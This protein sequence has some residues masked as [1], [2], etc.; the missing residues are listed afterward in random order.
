MNN[1]ILAALEQT[2]LDLKAITSGGLL[3]KVG[4]AGIAAKNLVNVYA[5][6]M[7]NKEIWRES[8]ETPCRQAVSKVAQE[9]ISVK[10]TIA[11]QP[12]QPGVPQTYLK[13]ENAV[14]ALILGGNDA[15]VAAMSSGPGLVPDIIVWPDLVEDTHTGETWDVFRDPLLSSVYG[16]DRWSTAAKNRQPLIQARPVV[17]QKIKLMPGEYDSFRFTRTFDADPAK[18]DPIHWDG[19]RI[20]YGEKQDDKIQPHEITWGLDPMTHMYADNLGD[21]IIH[22]GRTY[23]EWAGA[24]R[25]ENLVFRGPTG[26]GSAGITMTE[27]HK[28][29]QGEWQKMRDLEWINC[30]IDGEFSMF[31]NMGK[32]NKWGHRSYMVGRSSRGDY[33]LKFVGCNFHGISEEH[34]IYTQLILGTLPDGTPDE[35]AKA[36]LIKDCTFMHA[37]RTA[38]QFTARIGGTDEDH[39][40]GYVRVENNWV[41][42]VCVQDQGG[43]SAFSNNGNHRGLFEYID[44]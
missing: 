35:D 30:E 25:L 31:T 17:G 9:L 14:K 24:I 22:G 44:Y 32:T 12:V 6:I 15:I 20:I 42:D 10:R 19:T 36:V 3:L 28:D 33:G 29:S 11:K 16:A 23:H 8:W 18:L 37:G 43:G 26:N 40:Y 39:S 1:A 34:C 7:E 13:F 4:K 38:C 21:V 5:L 41:E 2:F 27:N